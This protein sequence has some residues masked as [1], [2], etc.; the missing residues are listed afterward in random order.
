MVRVSVSFLNFGPRIRYSD[1]I[2]IVFPAFFY[3]MSNDK[4]MVAQLSENFSA[5][6]KTLRFIIVFKRGHRNCR[7][8]LLVR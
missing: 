1:E 5:I 4:L 8:K 2:F 6:Y 7:Y 3:F